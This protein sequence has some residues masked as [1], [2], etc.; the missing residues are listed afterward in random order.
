MMPAFSKQFFSANE[1]TQDERLH[2]AEAFSSALYYHFAIAAWFALHGAQIVAWLTLHAPQ[3]HASQIVASLSLGPPA[4]LAL[5]IGCTMFLATK[6]IYEQC[7]FIY[8]FRIRQRKNELHN[9]AEM[10]DYERYANREEFT[11]EQANVLKQLLSH[12]NQKTAAPDVQLAS[13]AGRMIPGQ[14]DAVTQDDLETVCKHFETLVGFNL[15]SEANPDA[16]IK[17]ADPHYRSLFSII[18]KIRAQPVPCR[19]DKNNK[20]TMRSLEVEQLQFLRKNNYI[21]ANEEKDLETGFHA[22]VFGGLMLLATLSLAAACGY[23]G[24][25]YPFTVFLPALLVSSFRAYVVWRKNVQCYGPAQ[26]DGMDVQVKPELKNAVLAAMG[27]GGAGLW[28]IVNP[29]AIL[30]GLLSYGLVVVGAAGLTYLFLLREYDQ[31]GIL[32]VKDEKNVLMKSTGLG[33]YVG[34]VFYVSITSSLLLIGA[35]AFFKVYGISL[36]TMKVGVFLLALIFSK[37]YYNKEVQINAYEKS[38]SAA[39]NAAIRQV[40]RPVKARAI[41][42]GKATQIDKVTKLSHEPV[43]TS[44][45]QQ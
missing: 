8:S 23:S 30:P 35:P 18:S 12:Y 21:Q 27:L 13:I 36:V 26:R 3:L 1:A 45:C 42:T 10:F 6:L 41:Q 22:L 7:D 43:G 25:A 11:S 4:V 9:A 2:W 40:R 34:F 44:C 5:L 33:L 19:K 28:L 29:V 17:S 39:Y 16:A 32:E 14:L 20:A 24:L 15:A 37:S 38:H 31:D